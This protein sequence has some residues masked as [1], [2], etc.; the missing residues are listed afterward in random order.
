MG[1]N[2][3][4]HCAKHDK[5]GA[6]SDKNGHKSGAQVGEDR[7]ARVRAAADEKRIGLSETGN[8]DDFLGRDKEN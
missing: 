6:T 4:V 1:S 7:R 8:N 2:Q 5:T 3:F